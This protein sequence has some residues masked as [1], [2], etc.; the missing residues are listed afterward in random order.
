MII[1]TTP[2]H[3]FNIAFDTSEIKTL[4]I[5]YAQEEEIILKK[6]KDDCKLEGNKIT[7]T[8][9]QAETFKFNSE[10]RVKIQVRILTKSGAA[11]SSFTKDIPAY[12]CLSNEVLE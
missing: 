10:K 4:E 8:L 3:I 1:G 6:G 9:T 5:T 11:L 12:K 7:T 2:T